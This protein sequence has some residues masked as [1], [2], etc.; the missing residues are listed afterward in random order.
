MKFKVS[1]HSSADKTEFAVVSECGK[2]IDSFSNIEHAQKKADWLN[3][4]YER[5]SELL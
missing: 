3:E 1:E 4:E 2:H 5:I